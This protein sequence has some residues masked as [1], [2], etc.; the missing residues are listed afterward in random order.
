M[1]FTNGHYSDLMLNSVATLAALGLPVFVYCF[2][3][4]AVQLCQDLGIPYFTPPP[5]R[6]MEAADFRQDQAKFLEMGVH[7]PEMVLRLFEGGYPSASDI[8][9]TNNG[10]SKGAD[11]TR[12]RAGLPA[13][14]HAQQVVLTDTDTVWLRN[15]L[16]Y[17]NRHPSADVFTTTDCTNHEAEAYLIKEGR[18]CAQPLP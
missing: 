6:F 9:A 15:P 10:P 5:D 1:T 3:V 8:P 7:K 2:D 13:E 16:E 12:Q 18:R 14:Y 17:L 4:Q 11:F